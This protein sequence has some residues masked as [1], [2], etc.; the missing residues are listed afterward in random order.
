MTAAT[1]KQLAYIADLTEGKIGSL[2][3][4]SRRT[5]AAVGVALILAL[6]APATSAEASE[7]INSLKGSVMGYWRAPARKAEGQAIIDKLTAAFGAD[8]AG[9]P[10]ARPIADH[11][12]YLDIIRAAIEA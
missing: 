4:G 5:E 10:A 1:A 7:I 9:A 3:N 11:P 6:P 2:R 8:M 12:D